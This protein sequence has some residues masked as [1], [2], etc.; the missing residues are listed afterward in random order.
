MEQ[1]RIVDVWYW[2]EKA[3]AISFN[4]NLRADQ[5]VGGEPSWE[6]FQTN[7]PPHLIQD[8]LVKRIRFC[9]NQMIWDVEALIA[10]TPTTLTRKG[11]DAT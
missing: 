5:P 1:E 6:S 4:P 8:G 2:T 10:Q 9:G 7:M 11:E 3:E